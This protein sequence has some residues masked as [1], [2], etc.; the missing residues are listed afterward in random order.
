MRVNERKV[1]PLSAELRV[2]EIEV[3]EI[4]ASLVLANEC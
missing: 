3:F 4:L 1:L 2:K